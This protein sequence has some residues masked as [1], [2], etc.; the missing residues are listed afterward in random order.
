[1]AKTILIFGAAGM[2]GHT[3]MIS[4]ARRYTVVATARSASAAL[5]ALARNSGVPLIAGIEAHDTAQL[6]ATLDSVK[7]DVVI[8]CIGVVKQL[9][10]AQL[11]LVAIP[12]NSVL[13]HRLAE[14]C[15]PRGVRLIHF[16]TDCVFSGEAGPYSEASVPDARDLYGRS[17][18]LGEV[19]R[20]NALTLRTSIIGHE[21][22]AASGLLEW[23]IRNRGGAVSGFARALYTGVTTNYMAEAIFRLIDDFPRLCGVWQLSADSIS[24][25]DLIELVD[26]VYGL[27][28]QI[29]RDEEFRCDRRLDSSLFR[30]RTGIVPPIWPEMIEAMHAEHKQTQQ[31]N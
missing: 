3:L 6:E 18:L 14:L 2:L 28:L 12:V 19:N 22:G 9:K 7:P 21:L 20:P 17:K 25:Y 11:P 5:E 27:D 15:E 16:S 1:M 31:W 29:A 10:N 26:K 13:P 8:N 4:L 23:I 30:Q 24:K